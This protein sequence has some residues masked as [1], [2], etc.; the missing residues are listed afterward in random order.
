MGTPAPEN[1]LEAEDA[2][3]IAK[4]PIRRIWSWSRARDAKVWASHLGPRTLRIRE[5]EFRAYLENKRLTRARTH[6]HGAGKHG[7]ARRRNAEAV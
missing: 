4:V 6:G 1:L 5:R 7:R 3:A 2:A